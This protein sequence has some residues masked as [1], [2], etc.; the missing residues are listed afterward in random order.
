MV[1][2]L[3]PQETGQLFQNAKSAKLVQCWDAIRKALLFHS[4]FQWNDFQNLNS[5]DA[6]GEGTKPKVTGNQII[7]Q[8]QGLL[9]QWKGRSV[10]NCCTGDKVLGF[11]ASGLR[12]WSV[13]RTLALGRSQMFCK[14]HSARLNLSVPH[15]GFFPMTPD[16]WPA[17]LRV[18]TL[19]NLQS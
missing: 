5:F 10:L 12:V 7:F 4:V 8:K 2:I 1:A 15:Q 14:V 6:K 17:F 13:Q 9:L 18:L 3:P 19:K 16:L 11:R